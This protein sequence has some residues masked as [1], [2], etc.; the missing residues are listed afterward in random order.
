MRALNK[1]L[2]PAVAS[3]H[4]LL[5]EQQLWPE[6]ARYRCQAYEAYEAL[7]AAARIVREFEG[8]G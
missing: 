2:P 7:C 4:G 6:Q 3:L 5:D 8:E 1:A